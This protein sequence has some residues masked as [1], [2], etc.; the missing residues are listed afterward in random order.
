[1]DIKFMHAE[2][3]DAEKSAVDAVLGA[4]DSGWDGGDH[5]RA[6]DR[7]ARLGHDARSR[8]DEL[9]PALHGLQ[10]RIGWISEGGLNY[11]CR[12]LTIPPADAYGVATFYALLSVQER[13]PIVVHVCDDTACRAA[14]VMEIIEDLESIA[15]ASGNADGDSM[16]LTSPCLGQCDKGSAAFIQS[17]G[18]PNRVIAPSPATDIVSAL[19][20]EI[21]STAP[22][23]GAPQAGSAGLQLLRRVGVVDPWDLEDYRFHGGY[24]ALRMAV[25]MGPAAVLREIK[26]AEVRGRGG[27]AFPAG[28][29]WQGAAS[30]PSRTKYIVCNADESETGT[31]KD[32]VLMEG[33]PYAVIEAMTIAGYA[34]G[35]E[36]G[37][38]YI[39]GEYPVAEE[40]LANAITKA[41]AKGLL[42]SDVL[43]SGFAFDV[44]IRR[45]AGAYICGEETALF[46]SIE[47]YRG[48]P[49]S[50]P[51]FPT[52]VGLF[53]EPTVVNN[54]ETLANVPLILMGGGPG[55][56]ASGTGG[57]NGTKLFCLA[58]AV[59]KPGVYEVPFGTTIR[60]LLDLAGG[61]RGELHAI[62]V[63]GAAGRFLPIS[64]LDT[65]LTFEHLRDIKGTLGSGA[66]M[67]FNTEAD[68]GAAVRRVAAF[69]RDESCGQCVPCRVGTVRQEEALARMEAGSDERAVLDDLAMVLRDASIC[70][71][72][73]LAAEAVQSAFELGVLE[74]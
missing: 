54:V 38:L 65:P 55:F 17:A 70:G 14:G 32:R 31:F 45:G 46:N 16:W 13:P 6:D 44:E 63:G 23:L 2:A 39:R 33:D 37:Y 67:V 58:G 41:R 29:K 73:Q 52:D 47:G 35:A 43:G 24:A 36:K 66:I 4:P 69:F 3:T 51:P 26:D 19:A 48:E 8:R 27:A 1:M 71:L 11:I 72:G 59:E 10:D 30:H 60:E 64:R 61:V 74:S 15:G 53:G 42:G 28:I 49:R 21:P 22:S 5:S 34:V 7:I 56:A 9:L 40:L 25:H 20:G 12:R 57:S 68:M 50:K 18:A 62:L